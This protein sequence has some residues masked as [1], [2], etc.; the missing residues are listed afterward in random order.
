MDLKTH[1]KRNGVTANGVFGDD[2]AKFG[3]GALAFVGL[4][5]TCDVEICIFWTVL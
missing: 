3:L 5:L 2:I 4:I 1:T